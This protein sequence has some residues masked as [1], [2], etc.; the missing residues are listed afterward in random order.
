M[1]MTA[2]H[3][4]NIGVGLND[5]DRSVE[6]SIG[7][8]MTASQSRNRW[9]ITLNSYD[10]TSSQNIVIK[11]CKEMFDEHD[12]WSSSEHRALD[13]KDHS[14]GVRA[15]GKKREIPTI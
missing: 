6:W 2:R 11:I 10:C 9:G 3:D 14:I 13:D 12:R 8:S 15:A 4:Q 5:H 1:I 7:R